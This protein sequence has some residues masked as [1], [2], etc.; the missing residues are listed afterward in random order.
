MI[1]ALNRDLPYDQFVYQQIA[2]VERESDSLG[3]TGQ[4]N[5]RRNV[6]CF[7]PI[8]AKHVRFTIHAIN[9]GAQPCLDELEVF[10]NPVDDTAPANVALASAGAHATASTAPPAPS[11]TSPLSGAQPL[12]QMQIVDGKILL[13]GSGLTAAISGAP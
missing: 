11:D 1:E 2:E 8:V 3:G 6:D 12:D 9:N 10:S 5:P 7:E 4:I 13:S